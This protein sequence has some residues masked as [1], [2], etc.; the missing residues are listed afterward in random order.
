MSVASAPASGRATPEARVEN[1]DRFDRVP[2]NRGGL[3]FLLFLGGALI[4]GTTGFVIHASKDGARPEVHKETPRPKPVAVVVPMDASVAPDLA[5]TPDL[6][7]A[8]DAAVA[9]AVEPNSKETDPTAATTH[10][11]GGSE[12]QR[13]VR[14][15]QRLADDGDD[16]GALRSFRKALTLHPNGTEALFGIAC[17]RIDANESEAD[18]LADRAL[19]V[20]TMNAEAYLAKGAIAQKQKRVA[21]ARAAYRHYLYL[22]PQGKFA[23]EIRTILETLH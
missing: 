1:T 21:E 22:A 14:E 23:P 2:R 20:D 19:R 10:V 15:G 4:V 9:R 7:V 13:L 16:D 8:P 3:Y 18:K 17:A 6:G 5:P 11:E 12:Y